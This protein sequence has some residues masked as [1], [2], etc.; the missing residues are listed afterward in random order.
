MYLTEIARDF[1][2]DARFP[3]FDRCDWT[4]TARE[5][6]AAGTDGLEYAF[7]TYERVAH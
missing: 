7:A 5:P 2:G 4:E 3:P 6:G 1:A